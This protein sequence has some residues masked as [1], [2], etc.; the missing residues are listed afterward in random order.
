M[1]PLA[2]TMG[3]PAG[4]GGEITLKCWA[5]REPGDAPFFIV[6]DPARLAALGRRVGLAVTQAQQAAV[7]RTQHQQMAIAALANHRQLGTA[8]GGDQIGQGIAMTD[9]QHRALKAAQ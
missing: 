7:R 5:E 4:I 1:L 2:L 9:H 8:E 6:D 3:E